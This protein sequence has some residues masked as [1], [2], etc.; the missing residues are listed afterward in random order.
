MRELM[1]WN[2]TSWYSV[3]VCLLNPCKLLQTL[4]WI[5]Y[6]CCQTSID[7]TGCLQDKNVHFFVP[8][9][10]WLVIHHTQ[11]KLSFALLHKT[12][13]S[14]DFIQKNIKKGYLLKNYQDWNLFDAV[15]N[16]AYPRP[17]LLVEPHHPLILLKKWKI[18]W[19]IL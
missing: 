4:C 2:R 15:V 1:K 18:S 8:R 7:C 10:F 12:Y 3:W 17:Q 16:R 14:R 6:F 13:F 9:N 5:N 19:L 11:H